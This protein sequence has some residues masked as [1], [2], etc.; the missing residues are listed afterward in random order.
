MLAVIGDQVWVA[1]L[2]I[3]YMIVK[4]YLDERRAARTDNKVAVIAGKVEEVHVA[5]NGLT[6]RL[7]AKTEAEALSR[8][9][10]EER[11]RADER[12]HNPPAT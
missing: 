9:G 3:I 1:I 12:A 11:E 7:V 6:A 8:G 10:V 4:E 5:T 2:A